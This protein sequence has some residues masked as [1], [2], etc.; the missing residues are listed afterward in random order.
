MAKFQR[1]LADYFRRTSGGI[2]RSFRENRRRF[3]I[4]HAG[5]TPTGHDLLTA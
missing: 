4:S 3:D 2:A 5:P 1:S